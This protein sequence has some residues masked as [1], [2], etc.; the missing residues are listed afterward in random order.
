MQWPASLPQRLEV[1]SYKGDFGDGVI[2]TEMDAGLAFMRQRYTAVVE[3]HSGSITITID[4]YTILDQFWRDA[5]SRRFDWVHP[6][7]GNPAIVRFTGRPSI[8]ARSGMILR[9]TVSI[10]VLP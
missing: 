9:V 1:S 4:Q 3:P 6:I 2:R 8:A 5:K 7:T 10:E